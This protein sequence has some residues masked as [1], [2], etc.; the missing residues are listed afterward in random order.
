MQL[1]VL[2]GLGA[3]DAFVD[4]LCR[5]RLAGWPL[6]RVIWFANAAGALVALRLG[7]AADMPTSAEVGGLI[8]GET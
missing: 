1:E 4:P 3:G 2:T 7:C 5:G 6:E 8:G